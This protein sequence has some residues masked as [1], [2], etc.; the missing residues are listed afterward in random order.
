MKRFKLIFILGTLFLFVITGCNKREPLRVSKLKMPLKPTAEELENKENDYLL[1][2][3]KQKNPFRADHAVGNI[4]VDGGSENVLKGIIW[5]SQKPFAIIGDSVV[6]E[7]DYIDNKKV[8]KI[9]KDAVILDNNGKEE[10]LRLE[11]AP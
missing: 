3:L 11:V 7:G 6:M 9:D 8:I 4:A 2:E 5:D 1:Q 10:I